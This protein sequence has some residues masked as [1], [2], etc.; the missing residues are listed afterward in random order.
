MFSF[1]LSGDGALTGLDVIRRANTK[2]RCVLIEVGETLLRDPSEDLLGQLFNPITFHLRRWLPV[3]RDAYQ[4][5]VILN[6]LAKHLAGQDRGPVSEP[7]T[8]PELFAQ[9][10]QTAAAKEAVAPTPQSLRASLAALR[11]QI[12]AVRARRVAVYFFEPPKHPAL[13]GSPY[14]TAIRAAVHAA[15]PEVP[16]LPAADLTAYRTQDGIHLDI[17]SAARYSATI[18]AWLATQP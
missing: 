6:K 9:L 10:V 5:G 16:W 15:F 8:R 1:A 18:E 3:L 14:S 4:P 13:F 17:P 2:P 12:D 7:T 11:S